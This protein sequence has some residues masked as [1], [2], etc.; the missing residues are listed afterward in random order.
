MQLS[1]CSRFVSVPTVAR[2]HQPCQLL[3]TAAPL[4]SDGAEAAL[5]AR[6]QWANGKLI[7]EAWVCCL[8]L[9]WRTIL[10]A[11]GLQLARHLQSQLVG[12]F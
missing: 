11:D 7:M 9:T 5:S 4:G 6:M 8:A 1:K 12:L 2:S 3:A 10:Q